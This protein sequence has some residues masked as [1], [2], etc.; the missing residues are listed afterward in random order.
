MLTRELNECIFKM[1]PKRNRKEVG[2]YMVRKRQPYN[3][4]KAFL[5]ENGIKHKDVAKLLDVA[6]N[7]VS[8]KL[9]GFGGDFTLG[10]AKL[11]HSNFGIPISYFFELSVPK[12]EP[13]VGEKVC[14]S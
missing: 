13:K 5:V 8:K 11:L 3:K 9:N 2:K 6:P 7:T 1:F 14:N 4:I 10:D 12:K